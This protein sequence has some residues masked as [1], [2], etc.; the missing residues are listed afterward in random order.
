MDTAF[1]DCL[2]DMQKKVA[3]E[4][5]RNILVLAAAGSGKTN[6]LAVRIALL[7]E[8]ERAAPEEI[9]CLTFTNRACKEMKERIVQM[10]DKGEDVI[11]KTFHS[12][13]YTLIQEFSK[14]SDV[15]SDFTIF[16]EL[17][18][19]TLL[20]EIPFDYLP[21]NILTVYK[22][23]AHIKEQRL[24]FSD[25]SDADI[26]SE[27]AKT[28]MDKL[29]KI[30]FEDGKLNRSLL[31]FLLKY[32][33]SL[34]KRYD[35]MLLERRALDFNDILLYAKR[36]LDNPE[37]AEAISKRFSYIH[38]DEVQDTTLVEYQIL[39]RI[40]SNS[41]LLLCG[42]YF[43]T[44]YQWRGSKPRDIFTGYTEKYNPIKISFNYQYRSTAT[45]LEASIAF[46]K[47]SF[48]EQVSDIYGEEIFPYSEERGELIEYFPA[49]CVEEEAKFIY[50]K[51]LELAPSDLSKVAILCRSNAYNRK[52]SAALDEYNHE[53]GDKIDF[54][55]A[56]QIKFFQSDEIKDVTA[57]LRLLVNRYDSASVFRILLRYARGMNISK[58]HLLESRENRKNG[59]AL[60][61]FIR[62]DSVEKFD[63][64]YTL[65]N[66][67]DNENIVIFDVETT[68]TEPSVDEIIQ[69]AA[70]KLNSDG[71]VKESFQ[72]LIK[73]TKSVGASKAV[74]HISDE[75]L[76]KEGEDP[77]Y[78]LPAFCEF[79][80]GCVIV[81]HN[82]GFDIAILQK[83]LSR[84]G[85]DRAEILD[86]YDTLDL[87]RRFYPNLSNHKLETL[88]NLLDTQVKSSHDA[89]DDILAT[90]DILL[91]FIVKFL[92]P[93]AEKRIEVFKENSFKKLAQTIS[94]LRNSMFDFS[95]SKLVENIIEAINI[96]KLKK[97][98]TESMRNLDE[99]LEICKE[100]EKVQ[101][102]EADKINEFLKLTVLSSTN[103][104]RL[105]KLHPK[106]PILTVHQAKGAE[107]D[108][109]FLA[110]LQDDSFPT[111]QAVIKKDLSEER[112]TFYVAMTRPKKR[113]FLSCSLEIDG[114][115]KAPSRFIN[116]I[117]KKYIIK[118][119]V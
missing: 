23:L 76:Q 46:L 10:T 84:L 54:L 39:E 20:N 6:A 116:E 32:A 62:M 60:C 78:V 9:L 94:T 103:L 87:A 81:G 14:F 88:S 2:N 33:P 30:C 70:I 97:D 31:Y 82:V 89:M 79:V 99:L 19:Q 17:D 64:F 98:N 21:G 7:L 107:F 85:L 40:F 28:H 15:S 24:L 18:C 49:Q 67:F 29:E 57:C 96:R 118:A 69:I 26:V 104:D 106:V 34:I 8:E 45:L 100:A 50:N 43:Q 13:C 90:K 16:D 102:D 55:L 36:I 77:I 4:R 3:T 105:L 71:T 108:A 35:L 114:R 101:G 63:P 52:L 25:K 113:L 72:K 80:K 5:D 58:L 75:K 27:C 112:R 61:D 1:I 42:D 66:S 73:A 56:E 11:V 109:V 22:F 117:P 65:L 115:K 68:G 86:D 92:K 119:I 83:Q 93:N 59:I 53:R 44:I 12:F 38:I 48:P 111:Y 47:V 110:G 91:H 51:I 37:N 74:H 41:K 95:L